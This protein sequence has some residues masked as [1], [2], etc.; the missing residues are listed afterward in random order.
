MNRFLLT[1]VIFFTCLNFLWSAPKPYI[2]KGEIEFKNGERRE[3]ALSLDYETDLV[4]MYNENGTV[5]TYSPFSIAS[6]YF[7]DELLSQ[8]RTFVTLQH[9]PKNSK[10][11][12]TGFYFYELIKVGHMDILRK[13]NQNVDYRKLAEVPFER[14][15][16]QHD[17]K[18]SYFIFYNGKLITLKEF[19]VSVFPVLKNRMGKTLEDFVTTRNIDIN[20]KLQPLVVVE[21][22]NAIAEKNHSLQASIN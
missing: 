19:S 15:V 20:D 13:V 22:I 7:Y 21:F 10:I 16:K 2:C 1:S 9:S 4:R 3:G 14:R 11:S 18:F 17:E 6:L 5:D 8:P 12:G